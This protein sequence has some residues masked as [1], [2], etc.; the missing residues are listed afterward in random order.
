[1]FRIRIL[2]HYLIDEILGQLGNSS[3]FSTLDLYSGFYQIGL[4][5]ESRKYTSFSANGK[6]WQ[7]K[8][9][10]MGLKNAPA[11]FQR[12]M[13]KVLSKLLRTCCFMYMV[14]VISLG[15]TLKDHVENLRKIFKELRRNDLKLQPSKCSFLRKEVV[16]LGHK[17]SREGIFPDESKFESVRNFPIPKSR[18]MVRSFLGLTGYY[19]KFIK[20]YGQIAAPLIS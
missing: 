13:T 12:M 14:D 8:R 15:M 19:R 3:Y 16:F 18:K 4:K 10:P 11:Y 9:L 17:V 6:K 7:Y 5:E 2:Y 20:D 1:M